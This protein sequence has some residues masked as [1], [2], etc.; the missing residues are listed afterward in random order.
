[1]SIKNGITPVNDCIKII[2]N[3][4]VKYNGLLTRTSTD[5]IIHDVKRWQ[6][7]FKN[8]WVKP[9]AVFDI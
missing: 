1:M 4:F 7:M 2:D 6:N 5:T 8:A 9:E 3:T